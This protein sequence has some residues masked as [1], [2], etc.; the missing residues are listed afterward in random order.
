[1]L[2]NIESERYAAQN[3]KVFQTT[4]DELVALLGIHILMGVNRLPAVKD[5]CSV[6]EKL[7]NPPMQK[8]MT[9]TRFWEILKNIH[10]A[11]N[12]QNL[13]LRYSEQYDRA[14]KL[15]PLIDHLLHLQEAML[16]ESHQSIDK[17]MCKFK[18][19][20]LMH[21]YMKNKSIK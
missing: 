1:M 9:R 20:S 21:Q 8:A 14:W 4:N 13:C 11:D 5:Y 3:G 7:G 18:G 12:V 10:F 19:K 2:I 15:Q 17:H 6:K 16:P